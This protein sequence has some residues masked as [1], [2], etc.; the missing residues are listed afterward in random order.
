MFDLSNLASGLG[1]SITALYLLLLAFAIA[2]F[3]LYDKISEKERK[4]NFLIGTGL[5]ILFIFGLAGAFI[6]PTTPTVDVNDTWRSSEGRT[7]WQ[8]NYVFLANSQL[9]NYEGYIANSEYYDYESQVITDIAESIAATAKTE[10]EAINLALQYVEDNV[11]YTYT[12]PDSVCLEGSAPSI[13]A[14]GQGQCDT[15]S[16]VLISILRKMGVAAKPVGGCIVL[17]SKC[18]LQS[19]FQS[20]AEYTG[21]PRYTELSQIDPEEISFSRGFFQSRTGGLH[22]WVIAW[23]PEDGWLA[24]EATNGKLADTSCYFYHVE[25]LP[26]DDSREDICVSKSWNYAK[27]C[28][29]NNLELLDKYGLGLVQEVRP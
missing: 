22:A 7:E 4:R 23:T 1:I 14:S 26:E 9:E 27:A 21:S 6:E 29:V 19:I 13:L 25:L 16:I 2:V 12:E 17:N 18:A 24:L 10:R 3:I 20:F 15:Q 11:E 5:G 28:S 8:E